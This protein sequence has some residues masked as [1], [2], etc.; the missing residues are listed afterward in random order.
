MWE[1]S[2][3]ANIKSA[4]SSRSPAIPQSRNVTGSGT[5]CRVDLWQWRWMLRNGRPTRVASSTT[6]GLLSTTW[7]C[8]L[9]RL[10]TTGAARTPGELPGARRATSDWHLEIL[11]ASAITRRTPQ[12]DPHKQSSPSSIQALECF[13]N[14]NHSW[15]WIC[16]NR[17]QSLLKAHCPALLVSPFINICFSRSRTCP[18][19]WKTYSF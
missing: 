8:W 16:S 14:K 5:P 18:L 4:V 15:T 19:F 7:S 1:S 10:T 6:V 9:G 3:N 13:N 2:R 12:N 17:W 11:A